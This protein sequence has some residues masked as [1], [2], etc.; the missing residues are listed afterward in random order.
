MKKRENINIVTEK[1]KRRK[2]NDKA[3]VMT[4]PLFTRKYPES[5]VKPL[6]EKYCNT[7]KKSTKKRIQW[8]NR[9]KLTISNNMS[10]RNQKHT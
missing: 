3:F 7:F 4:E 5:N 1:N 6:I 10:C 2:T 9:R 8:I